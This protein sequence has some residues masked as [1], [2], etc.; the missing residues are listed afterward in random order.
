MGDAPPGRCGF[1]MLAA[2]VPW[3]EIADTDSLAEATGSNRIAVC[4]RETAAESDRCRWH[5]EGVGTY[6]R[7]FPEPDHGGPVV[8]DGA[9]LSGFELREKRSVTGLRMRFATLIEADLKRAD[10]P[11]AILSFANLSEADLGKT[12]LS[13][14]DLSRVNLSRADFSEAD[15][16][17]AD[18]RRADLS[19]ATLSGAD[20]PGVNFTIA[21]LAGADLSGADLPEVNL[22]AADLPEVNLSRTDLS[23]ANFSGANLSSAHIPRANL[24]GASLSRAD[25]QEADLFNADFS[26]ADLSAADLS[27]ANID[28]T[29]MTEIRARNAT[30]RNATLERTDLSRA[31]LFDADLTGTELYGAILSDIR[32]NDATEF[33]NHYIDEDDSVE[34][35]TW[36]LRQIEQIS[37]ES[38]LP[39]Q[40]T[41]AVVERKT[42]R[43]RHHWTEGNYLSWL[44]NAGFGLLTKYGES[45]GRVV[46]LSIGTI[47][48]SAGLFQH[49]GIR[50]TTSGGEVISFALQNTTAAN[51]VGKSL[52]L[53]TVTF[54]TVGYGDLQPVGVGQLVATVES[55]LGAL[56]MALLVFVLGRR[57]TR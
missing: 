26:E 7:E 13:E 3:F 49:T 30:L 44:R 6:A 56:L 55:F 9:E 11:E 40:V 22:A 50:D 2:D 31:N 48:V 38:A 46:G 12:D 16:S 57:A 19:D 27:R 54:T 28:D 14:A 33:G 4:R 8:L 1:E 17:E 35:A 32:L 51:L 23:G 37:R 21:T 15:L 24:S 18:L 53:S 39:E 43:R 10:L 34:R 20:L 5:T 52:Y 42:R 45:P 29:D 47:L 36:T 25:L 41:E